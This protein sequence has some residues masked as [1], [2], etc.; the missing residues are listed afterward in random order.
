MTQYYADSHAIRAQD[1]SLPKVSAAIGVLRKLLQNVKEDLGS[2]IIIGSI[3]SD[4]THFQLAVERIPKKEHEI[5]AGRS[6]SAD[7][8]DS[9]IEYSRPGMTVGQAEEWTF[10]TITYAAVR[11]MATG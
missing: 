11:E 5:V 6:G 10:M 8:T 4:G 2:Q 7:V 3:D 1:S 9:V